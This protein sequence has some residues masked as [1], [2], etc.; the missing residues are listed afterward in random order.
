MAYHNTIELTHCHSDAGQE[1]ALRSFYH[2]PLFPCYW[3]GV[4]CVMLLLM[5]LPVGFKSVY[6]LSVN[7]LSC[8]DYVPVSAIVRGVSALVF[9]PSAIVLLL[10]SYTAMQIHYSHPV[11]H[12]RQ[13]AF[14]VARPGWVRRG[15]RRLHLETEPISPA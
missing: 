13:P 10:I 7:V 14:F 9:R 2:H 6:S 3:W 8:L 12:I 15:F 1:N 5:A 4:F 11:W